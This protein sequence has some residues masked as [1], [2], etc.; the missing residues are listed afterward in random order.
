MFSTDQSAARSSAGASFQRRTDML[1]WTI[2]FFVVAV[3]ASLLGFSGL[4]G[5][6]AGIAKVLAVITIAIFA[7]LLALVLTASK[8]IDKAMSGKR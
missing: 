8:G 6:A 7:I 2:I 5:A 1:K 4:A 3:V